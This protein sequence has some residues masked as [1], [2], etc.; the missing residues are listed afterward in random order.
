MHSQWNAATKQMRK[1]MLKPIDKSYS[2]NL[3]QEPVFAKKELIVLGCI[4]ITTAHH[5]A[6]AEAFRIRDVIWFNSWYLLG[7][8]A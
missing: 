2:Q 8:S 5:S 1:S 7:S 6:R 4:A 3:Q